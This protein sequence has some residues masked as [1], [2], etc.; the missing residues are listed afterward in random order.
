MAKANSCCGT[1]PRYR[2]NLTTIAVDLVLGAVMGMLG[3]LL[4]IGGGMLV[5]PILGIWYGMDQ[6]HAQGT[7][8]AMVVPNIAVG[9]WQYARRGMDRRLAL[10][11]ACAAAPL[12]YLG[13]HVAVV[14]P[15]RPLRIS[16]ALFL[17]TIAAYTVWKTLAPAKNGTP[18]K[19]LP[20]PFATIV[21]AFGGI[22][23]GLFSVGGAIF[24]VPIMTA[25]FGVTQA[26]AQG[27]G[28]ALVAPGT[29]VG[30]ATY[31]AAHDVDWH[32]GI[33]LAIGGVLAVPY[34][35]ALA[36]RIPERTLRLLFATLIAIAAVGLLLRA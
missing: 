19:P 9:L 22:L 6:Q 36:Y 26:A 1:Y 16:F 32:V 11:L 7:A 13:A 34:G 27:L 23:S 25:F 30:I 24:S 14:V 5:I 10:A 8:M 31:A 4:G 21:G 18:R 33:P 3:G 12:T 17:L 35:V 29:L 28:L 20:W 15:S 2:L